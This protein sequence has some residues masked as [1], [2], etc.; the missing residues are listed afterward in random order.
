MI[1]TVS[2]SLYSFSS[3]PESSLSKVLV[4]VSINPSKIS[5]SKRCQVI[6]ST[7]GSGDEVWRERLESPISIHV[8]IAR[9]DLSKGWCAQGPRPLAPE[10]CC[11]PRVSVRAENYIVHCTHTGN[12]GPA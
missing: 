3:V 6:I 1:R 11:A 4:P 10:S 12:V 5:L 8:G 2:N 9:E 7:Q